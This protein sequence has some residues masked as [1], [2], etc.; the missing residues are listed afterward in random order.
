MRC[1]CSSIHDAVFY[2]LIRGSHYF[3]Y[4][5][6]VLLYSFSFAPKTDWS[7]LH[8]SGPEIAQY[9]ADVCEKYSIVDKIQ[10]NTEINEI[11]WLDGVEEWE[12]TLTHLVPGTGDLAQSEQAAMVARDGAYSVYIKTE[13]VRAK[14][15]VTGA[16]GLV[17]PN[18]WPK[19]V[20]GIDKFEGEIMHTAKWNSYVD[21]R[22]KNVVVIGSGCSAAQVVPSLVEH[23]PKSVT[24]V[25]RSP[26]WVQPDALPPNAL[27]IYEKWAPSLMSK[28]P[29]LAYLARA[30]LFFKLEIDFL[31]VFK[32]NSY[33]QRQRIRKEKEYLD[34]MRAMA[35]KEYH[36]ILTPD[37][38]FGC[39]RRIIRADWY[40]SLH[41]L[42]YEL[43]TLRLTGVQPRSVVLGPGKSYPPGKTE[44]DE[45]REVPADVIVLANGFETNNW[46][47]PL[48]VVGRG[49]KLMEELW[50]ERGGAQA[51]LG[52]A[53]DRFPNCFIIFGPNNATGHTSVIFATENAVNYS[54][55]FIK[56]ILDGDVSSYEISEKAE[57]E[58][59]DKVQNGLQGTVFQRGACMSWYQTE[60]GWN[61]STY[62]QVPLSINAYP[63]CC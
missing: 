25:M 27:K 56:P 52:I 33:S 38:S 60:N 16:G 45:V 6:P 43:T 42:N 59:T 23:Q 4:S 15:V 36:E 48:R 2:A 32:N 12:V 55:N 53:M 28:V 14:I 39:K 47:H 7:T 3:E 49:G 63:T 40:K 30:I 61:S 51:Y 58:W 50:E 24:Q 11:K 20:P 22:D 13:T 21:L 46:L 35:P 62:P 26:P 1:V 29:G 19:N 41:N 10:L 57:R 31:A 9:L 34:H 44:T 37:Y 18:P 17:E 8:P 54:L 5:R